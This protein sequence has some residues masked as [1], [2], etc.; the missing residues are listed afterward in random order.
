MSPLSFVEWDIRIGHAAVTVRRRRA[1]LGMRGWQRSDSVGM[2]P[3]EGPDGGAGAAWPAALDGLLQQLGQA[4]APGARARVVLSDSMVRYAV[5]P[6]NPA[7]AGVEEEAVFLR[8]RFGQLYDAGTA[9]WD[10]R[11]DRQHG[12]RARIASAV[13][14]A[15]LAALGELLRARGIRLRSVVPALA[16]TVGR[17]L[18]RLK[19]PAGWLLSHDA[20]LLSMARWEDGAWMCA[21]S[22]RVDYRWRAVLPALL[23]RE[24]CLHDGQREA[25]AVYI[26]D[27]SGAA[28]GMPEMQ[29][30]RV[31]ELRAAERAGEGA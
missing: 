13:D 11:V 9:E 25:A 26:E 29:G 19:E 1:R 5:V 17:H 2:A 7:L 8:H 3:C 22:F 15:Q 10:I 23:A 18:S 28:G 31:Q 6:W 21:R 20:G 24:E 27:A 4:R 30:W 12:E 14:P 16:D